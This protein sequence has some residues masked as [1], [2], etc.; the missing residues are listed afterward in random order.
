MSLGGHPY[1]SR[2]PHMKVVLISGHDAAAGRKTGFHFWAEILDQRGIEVDFITVGSSRISLYK[3][4]GKQ[5]RPPFNTWVSMPGKWRRY[6]WLPPFHPINFS[7]RI[8]NYLSW[9][10]FSFY[11]LM[12]PEELKSIRNVDLFIVESGGGPLL[13]PQLAKRNP[14]AKFIYNFSDR[15]GVVDFHPYVVRQTEKNLSYFSMIRLNAAVVAND[16]PSDLPTV[17]IPQAIDKAL[18]DRKTP[19]PYTKPKNAINIGDMLF[20][21]K[22]V[23]IMAEK[24]PDWTFHLFGRGARMES[25][26]ANVIEHGEKPFD[27]IVPYLQHADI[28]LAPYGVTKEDTGYLSQSSLKLVQYTYCRLPIVT[29]QFATKD[30][31]HAFGYT[32]GIEAT[33]V[34]A[35][36]QAMQCDRSS[37]DV[38]GVYNWD[39]VIDRMLEVIKT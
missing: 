29:P 7:S 20:D 15:K 12:M 34:H 8:L 6:T 28:G 36:E 16:F 5:L 31:P 21:A 38:S 32:P 10:L 27:N 37:I 17:Y 30:R 23:A 13:V 4:N 3:K 19:N 35:F 33:I 24:F 39:Q 14:K 2:G 1:D 26:I 9:P 11:P 25:P 22:S 18:F